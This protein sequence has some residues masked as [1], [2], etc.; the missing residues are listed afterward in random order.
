[1]GVRRARAFEPT[2]HATALADAGSL[3]ELDRRICER[4]HTV[5]PL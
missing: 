2:T 4:L 1:V 5:W 3:A